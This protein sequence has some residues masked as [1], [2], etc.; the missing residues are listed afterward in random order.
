MRRLFGLSQERV[1]TVFGAIS[2]VSLADYL[3]SGMPSSLAGMPRL[4]FIQAD[5]KERPE[6]LEFCPPVPRKVALLLYIWRTTRL[7]PLERHEQ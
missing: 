3:P 4:V 1:T 7:Q 2:A 6:R 5:R